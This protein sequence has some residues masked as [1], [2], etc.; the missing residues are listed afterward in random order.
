MSQGSKDKCNMG[1]QT[2][3]SGDQIAILSLEAL[4]V[5]ALPQETERKKYVLGGLPIIQI[6]TEA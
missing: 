3:R 6:A 2:V 1:E 5:L 4:S